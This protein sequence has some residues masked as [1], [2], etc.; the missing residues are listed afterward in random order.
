MLRIG[1]AM[2]IERVM[3]HFKIKLETQIQ[4][5]LRCKTN[6]NASAK[7]WNLTTCSDNSNDLSV[8]ESECNNNFK[9]HE[10]HRGSQ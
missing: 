10:M 4:S 3:S 5:L 7:D 8:S 1:T 9:Q 2:Q 6:Y